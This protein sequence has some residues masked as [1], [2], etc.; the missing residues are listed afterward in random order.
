MWGERTAPP[1]PTLTLPLGIFSETAKD[2]PVKV[3]SG[4]CDSLNAF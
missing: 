1:T 2:V 3:L 4:T